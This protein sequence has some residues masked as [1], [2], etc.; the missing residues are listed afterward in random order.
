M[1]KMYLCCPKHLKP[2]M[3]AEAEMR[4]KERYLLRDDL[5]DADL[6]YVVGDCT[7]EMEQ[8]LV[9]ANRA[10][11][12]IVY[13]NEKFRNEKVYEALLSNKKQV[14]VMRKEK[15]NVKER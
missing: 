10:G 4:Y 3:K 12:P 9:R 7:E 15:S 14:C 5:E 11:I 13:A 8:E 1:Q 2:M 6:V